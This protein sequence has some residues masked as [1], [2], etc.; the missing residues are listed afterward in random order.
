M[1]ANALTCNYIDYIQE[2][3]CY[4]TIPACSLAHPIKRIWSCIL[5][6]FCISR[7]KPYTQPLWSVHTL[8][9]RS[10]DF[11]ILQVKLPSVGCFFRCGIFHNR[12]DNKSIIMISLI[13]VYLFLF[14]MLWYMCMRI[15][16]YSY[17]LLFPSYVE[18]CVSI[19]A[20]PCS[21]FIFEI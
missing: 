17:T 15:L 19:E 16:I 11:V 5:E 14:Y 13:Y 7:Y 1:Y 21:E 8:R 3:I 2:V 4:I 18:C 12:L 10:V 6:C 9:P 20:C